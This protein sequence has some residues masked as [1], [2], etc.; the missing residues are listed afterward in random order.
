MPK[1]YR[2]RRRS[3]KGGFLDNL[4]ST[5][6]NWSNSLY[7]GMSNLWNKTKSTTSYLTGTSS[8]VP[9]QPAYNNYIRGGKTR[10]RKMRGGYNANTPATGLAST[11]ASFSG[12]TA[13]P[14]T[15]VG[16]K[17]K[18]HSGRKSR[19]HRRH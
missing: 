18:R 2:N 4:S 16:G 9:P 15:Y 8:A 17:T 11:A 10:R 7:S 1:Q 5:A 19:R 12:Q 3:M 14:H 6:S 13:Q